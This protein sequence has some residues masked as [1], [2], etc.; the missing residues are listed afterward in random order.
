MPCHAGAVSAV[1]GITRYRLILAVLRHKDRAADYGAL[2]IKG[3]AGVVIA[4]SLALIFLVVG[5]MVY[6]TLTCKIVLRE[7]RRY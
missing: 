7:K 3:S 6:Q 5:N 4:I 2:I 1:E